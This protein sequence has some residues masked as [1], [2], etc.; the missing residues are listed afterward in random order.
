MESTHLLSLYGYE[1]G[2]NY[3]LLYSSNL[4]NMFGGE[5]ELGGEVLA[6][7]LNTRSGKVQMLKANAPSS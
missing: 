6:L 1:Q 3:C 4:G 5:V 2:T 7:L